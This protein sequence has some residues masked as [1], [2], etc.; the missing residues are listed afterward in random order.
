MSKAPVAQ[1]AD[2]SGRA[3]SGMTEVAGSNPRRATKAM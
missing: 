3:P 1:S 2:T